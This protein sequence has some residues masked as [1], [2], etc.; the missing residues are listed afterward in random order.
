MNG[1]GWHEDLSPSDWEYA[2]KMVVEAIDYLNGQEIPNIRRMEAPGQLGFIWD[3]Y[4]DWGIS[5]M[6]YRGAVKNP[7]IKVDTKLKLV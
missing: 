5:V 7:G 2:D 3:I 4:L 6:D 1:D